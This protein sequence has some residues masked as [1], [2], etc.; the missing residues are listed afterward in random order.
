MINNISYNQRFIKNLTNSC[1]YCG[2]P[3]IKP[4]ITYEDE[5]NF[6]YKDIYVESFE[7][8][9][10]R[11][12]TLIVNDVLKINTE[13]WVLSDHKSIYL[14]IKEVY[15]QHKCTGSVY[16]KIFFYEFHRSS[17]EDNLSGIDLISEENSFHFI[18]NEE[19]FVMFNKS[20]EMISEA[21]INVNMSIDTFLSITASEESIQNY[22]LLA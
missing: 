5:H 11:Q 21:V 16:N 15:N 14:N 8:L 20:I 10:N 6:D 2:E 18:C 3:T 13:F 7:P 17:S 12:D 22:L 9:R 1:L 19:R 4:T